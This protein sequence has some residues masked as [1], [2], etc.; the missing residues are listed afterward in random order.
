MPYTH[1][2]LGQLAQRAAAG[3]RTAFDALYAATARFQYY[4]ILHLVASPQVAEDL[5]QQADALAA[6][7]HTAAETAP[8]PPAPPE[9]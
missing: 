3:D 8:E 1:R 2:Q 9:A 7:V 6:A 4:R 5:L